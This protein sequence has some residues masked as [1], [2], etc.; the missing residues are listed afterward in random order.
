MLLFFISYG[1]MI[2]LK[3]EFQ[4][5]PSKIIKTDD[6]KLKGITIDIIN[7]I[8]KKT[9]YRF[10]YKNSDS[11]LLRIKEEL[12]K[13]RIDV[14]FGM[15]KDGGREKY[16]DFIEPLYNIHYVVVTLA[17]NQEK[18]ESIDDLKKAS[19]KTPVLTVFG[20]IIEDNLNSNGIKNEAGGK[21]IE[22]NLDKLLGKRANYVVYHDIAIHYG[23]NEKKYRGKFKVLKLNIKE[24]S[25]WLVVS[26]KLDKKIKDELKEIVR[27]LKKESEWKKMMKKYNLEENLK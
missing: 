1:N 22:T 15:L 21:S 3:T 17:E 23:I 8:Q 10:T 14:Y 7:M 9:D 24:D 16:I 26:F 4:N 13:N 20:S 11:T 25:L 2:T 5:T 18:I 27:N 19:Q 6:G 12:V